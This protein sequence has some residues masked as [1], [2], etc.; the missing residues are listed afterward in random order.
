MRLLLAAILCMLLI[1]PGSA[2]AQVY[3]WVDGEGVVHYSTGIES[4]PAPY[5]ARARALYASP[6]PAVPATDPSSLTTITFTPGSPVIVSA[7]INGLGPIILVLDTGADR[8]LVSPGALARLGIPVVASGRAEVRGVTG[9]GPADVVWIA[10]LEVG[11]AKAGPLAIVAYDGN[12]RQADGLL[13]RDFLDQFTV[14]IDAQTGRVTLA[15]H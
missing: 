4:V 3:H 11:G 15:P 2:L 10:S 14:T 13:G 8:T 1:L 9:A 5:R 6:P 12:L 7:R